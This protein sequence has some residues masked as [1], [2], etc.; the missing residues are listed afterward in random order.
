MDKRLL[1]FAF[2]SRDEAAFE[3]EFRRALGRLENEHFELL[4]E[5]SDEPG[6][7]GLFILKDAPAL[8]PLP[9]PPP[10]P[11]AAD[12]DYDGADSGMQS[13]V[14]AISLSETTESEEKPG[15]SSP[16][17]GADGS[18]ET[19]EKRGVKVTEIVATTDT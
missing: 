15:V 5:V 6:L 1:S 2:A 17:D 16:A 13:E 10:P 18:A 19:V 12:A 8:P 11:D 7:L 4:R 3:L 9:P 14:D